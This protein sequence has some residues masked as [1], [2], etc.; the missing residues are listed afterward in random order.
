MKQGL[1]VISILMVLV[2]ILTLIVGIA[3]MGLFSADDSTEAKALVG[4]SFILLVVGGL[5]DIIG[6]L[7]GLRAAKDPT[8]ATGAVVFGLLALIAGILSIVLDPSAQ[9]IGSCLIPLL[10]FI[11]AVAVRSKRA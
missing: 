9:S 5:L 11:F 3:S 10:Y 4:L 6:G 8:R 7:L 1:K 2:G